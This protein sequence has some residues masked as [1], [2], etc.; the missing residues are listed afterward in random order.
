MTRARRAARSGLD[1]ERLAERMADEWH[2]KGKFRFDDAGDFA[3][4]VARTVVRAC[5]R[6][7]EKAWTLED[8]CRPRFNKP[9]QRAIID[10]HRRSAAAIRRAARRPVRRT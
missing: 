1:L 7:A 2:T 8:V 9:V 6:V 5:A 3:L 4:R 10:A